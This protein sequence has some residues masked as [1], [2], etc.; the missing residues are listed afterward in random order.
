MTRRGGKPHCT[1]DNLS[2]IRTIFND[3]LALEHSSPSEFAYRV[4]N[5]A[6]NECNYDLFV[7]YWRAKKENP[8]AYLQCLHDKTYFNDVSDEPGRLPIPDPY[9]PFPDLAEVYIA[10]IML[11]RE[12]TP[13]EKDGSRW[14]PKIDQETGKDYLAPLKWIRWPLDYISLKDMHIKTDYNEG[15]LAVIFNI[16]EIRHKY[17]GRSGEGKDE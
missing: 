9:I 12:L 10:E 13:N 4:D 7:D 8:N 3:I 16:D 14:I 17:A 6:G 15:P 1:G 5:L 2:T 11:G